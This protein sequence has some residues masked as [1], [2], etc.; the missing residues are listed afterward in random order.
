MRRYSFA[1]VFSFFIIV[2]SLHAQQ[3]AIQTH[4][5]LKPHLVNFSAVSAYLKQH[6][7]KRK[8]HQLVEQGEDRDK[9]FKFKPKGGS[10]TAFNFNIKIQK[11][12]TRSVSPSP[13]ISFN[14]TLDNDYLIP[15]M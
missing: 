4:L 13:D 7:I 3:T 10:T 1:L 14:G 15:P 6:P 2:N 8:H 12:L 5:R 11:T 9:D